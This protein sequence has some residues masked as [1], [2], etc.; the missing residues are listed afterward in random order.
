MD[1]KNYLLQI[2]EEEAKTFRKV[3]NHIM[4]NPHRRI[5]IDEL[6]KETGVDRRQISKWLDEGR[7][8]IG[9]PSTTSKDDFMTEIIKS[10]DEL[11]KEMEKKK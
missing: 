8:T 7:L 2:M 9:K 1:K 5:T 3:R 10:R 4:D 6:A 11:I